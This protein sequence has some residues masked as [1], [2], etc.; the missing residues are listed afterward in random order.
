MRILFRLVLLT[1]ALAIRGLAVAAETAPPAGPGLRYYYPVPPADPPKVFDVDICVYGDTPA[2]IAAAIQARRLGK[3]SALFCFGRNVG[4]MT[5]GGL[6]ATDVGNAKAIGGMAREFYDRVGMLRGFR[7]SKAQQVFLEMLKEANVPVHLE[8]RLAKVAKDGPR[9]TEIAFENGNRAAAKVFIDAT[10]EGDLLAAADVSYHVG[11]ESNDTYKETLNGKQFRNAHNFAVA[12][13]PY[14]VE[15]DPASGL[16]WGISSAEPGE[17]GQGDRHVQAYNFRMFLSSAEDRIPFPKPPGYDPARYA[18]LARYLARHPHVPFQLREGDS[19]NTGGFSTDYIGGS[20]AWP[21]ADYPTREKIF[22]DHV[23]Y[24]QGLMFFAANDPSVPA[25]LRQKVS[26]FGLAA[27]EFVQTG[28]WPH[29]LYIRE[30]RRMVSDYV[31]TEHNCLGKVVAEDGIGLAS[32]NMDSH[33]CRRIVID[34]K[35]RN[36]GDVQVKCPRPYPVSYRSIVPRA[37][38]CTNLLVPVCLSSTHIAYGSIRMEPV[39]MVLGQSAA[40]AGSMAI[41]AGIPVQKVKYPKLR[42]KLVEMGQIVQWTPP[43]VSP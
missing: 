43:A 7:P 17:T 30:G 36:E 12:V 20:D 6:S 29:Q 5:A 14:K 1:A 42:A 18:L 8:H 39:F 11:R 34:G 13:D 25:D 28:G 31:M 16:L 32:Y 2:G 40:V 4:G 41:G 35:V 23:N 10:Y 21:E 9:I 26:R 24:Q 15:G 38:E 3:T 19:N 22:Q 37:N 27:G 33:N